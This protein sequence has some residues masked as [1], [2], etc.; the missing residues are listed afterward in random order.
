LEWGEEAILD[1][2][3]EGYKGATARKFMKCIRGNF[4][5][6]LQ[7]EYIADVVVRQ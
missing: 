1:G 3:S 4:R 5:K 7:E 6:G 2:L